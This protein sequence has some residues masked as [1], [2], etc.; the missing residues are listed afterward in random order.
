MK[1]LHYHTLPHISKCLTIDLHELPLVF[2][3][4]IVF[5]N[6]AIILTTKITLII[7]LS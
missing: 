4:F 3:F 1:W 7:Y 5:D 2:R 6:I